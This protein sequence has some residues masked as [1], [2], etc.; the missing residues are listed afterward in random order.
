MEE[1]CERVWGRDGEGNV[2][3]LKNVVYRLRRKVEADPANPHYILTVAGVG[4]QFSPK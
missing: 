4:Y 1:L 2:T 3:T